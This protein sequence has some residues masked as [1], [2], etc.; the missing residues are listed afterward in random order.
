LRAAMKVNWPVIDVPEFRVPYPRTYR[1]VIWN[2][3]NWRVF[4]AVEAVN[5]APEMSDQDTS[6]DDSWIFTVTFPDPETALVVQMAEIMLPTSSTMSTVVR[7][8]VLL[9]A[10]P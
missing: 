10:V 9:T 1:L 7:P 6:S 4:A 5:V 8:A 2:E 3:I